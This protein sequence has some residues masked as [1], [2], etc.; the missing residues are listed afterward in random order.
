MPTRVSIVVLLGVSMLLALAVSALRTKVRWPNATA[1]GVGLL[2]V[3]ELW[4][5]V[6][7][8]YP[9][10]VP[11]VYRTIAADPRPVRVMNLP[12]GLRD[13]LSSVGNTSAEFQYYQTVHEKP[14]VGGYVSR[15][16]KGAVARYRDYPVTSALMDLS[17]GQALAPDRRAEV[18][19]LARD[20]ERMVRLGVGWVAV[21]TARAS[22]ELEQFAIEAF[23]L[24]L[25]DRD[26]TWKL[27]RREPL[28]PWSAP[29]E[30]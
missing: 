10:A 27:Y 22:R 1:A 14:L 8:V 25:V 3:A 20:P 19:R 13:G 17:E 28:L 2:L 18:L 4:P 29:K 26:G 23:D 21:D 7:P 5:G 30:R 11:S 6:R 9:A 12:F 16:P 24:T 15:L